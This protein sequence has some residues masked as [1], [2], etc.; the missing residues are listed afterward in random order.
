MKR[1]RKELYVPLHRKK[2]K[3]IETKTKERASFAADAY[4]EKRMNVVREHTKDKNWSYDNDL[5]TP[6]HAVYHN[7]KTKEVVTAFRGTKVSD[8]TDLAADY[9]IVTGKFSSSPRAHQSKQL[10]GDIIEKYPSDAWNHI[11]AS[12][13]LG[14]SINMEVYKMYKDDIKEVHNF[15][16]GSGPFELITGL[17]GSRRDEK[18]TDHII[19]GD[20]IS[21]SASQTKSNNVDLIKAQDKDQSE[22]SIDQFLV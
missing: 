12:H 10:F 18:V 14:G 5:S 13:S 3:E 2:P 15:N 6:Y 21:F 7:K 17:F 9:Q 8:V 1:R 19:E 4:S 16:R 11:L 20:I 22:H